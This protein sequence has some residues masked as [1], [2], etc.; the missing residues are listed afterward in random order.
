MKLLILDNYDSFTY[1]LVHLVEK[2]SDISFDVIQNDKITLQEVN[3]YDKI[4]LSPGPGLPKESGI[5]P[6]LLNQYHKTKSILGVCLGL[7]AIGETFGATLLNLPTVFHGIATPINIINEDKI[8]AGCSKTFIAGRYHSWVINNDGLPNDLIITAVD[9]KNRIMAAKHKT[10]DVRGVQFHPESI[11][12]EHGETI[13]R[14][15]LAI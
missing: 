8:F 10:Y 14:N 2:V 1:N 5:M 3:K 9:D 15:W 4:L 7:Q 6:E 11:L 13:I 12:S